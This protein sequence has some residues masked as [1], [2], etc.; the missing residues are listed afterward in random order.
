MPRTKKTTPGQRR[1]SASSCEPRP[2]VCSLRHLRA[3]CCCWSCWFCP[4]STLFDCRTCNGCRPCQHALSLC[5]ALGTISPTSPSHS[6]TVLPTQCQAS[7]NTAIR[8][9]LHPFLFGPLTELATTPLSLC[10]PGQCVLGTSVMVVLSLR[11]CEGTL[12][13][14]CFLTSPGMTLQKT[15]QSATPGDMLHWQLG[16]FSI[17]S[18]LSQ[19]H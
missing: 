7:C 18:S 10:I 12:F 13:G 15:Q 16:L 17:W 14:S 4:T 3:C 8:S 6:Q 9:L 1:A 11:F 2:S 5:S 19:R